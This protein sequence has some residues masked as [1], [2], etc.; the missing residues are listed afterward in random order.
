MVVLFRYAFKNV[1]S[2][3]QMKRIDKKMGGGHDGHGKAVWA[4]PG[5]EG[6]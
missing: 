2:F 1:R 5:R 6:N 4:T 3:K